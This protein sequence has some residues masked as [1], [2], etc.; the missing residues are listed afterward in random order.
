L[1]TLLLQLSVKHQITLGSWWPTWFTG[2]KVTY[3][4]I[5]IV[6]TWWKYI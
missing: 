4:S 5:S 1:H 3:E 6:I 2:G